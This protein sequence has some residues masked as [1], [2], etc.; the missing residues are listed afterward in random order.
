M[1]VKPK[2]IIKEYVDKHVH[3]QDLALFEE[4]WKWIHT[5]KGITDFFFDGGTRTPDG[6]QGL[7][8]LFHDLKYYFGGSQDDRRIADDD[9]QMMMK[10]RDAPVW[11]WVIRNVLRFAQ[12]AFRRTNRRF[13]KRDDGKTW[14]TEIP[15]SLLRKSR[16]PLKKEK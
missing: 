12:F 8:Y 11:S 5:D 13:F 16:S 3:P 4:V 1:P 7:A 14:R 15:E 9:L 10:N 2:F 6:I